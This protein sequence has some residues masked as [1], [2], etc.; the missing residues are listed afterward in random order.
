MIS[1]LDG[2]GNYGL[3]STVDNEAIFALSEKGDV[4]IDLTK[5]NKNGAK[6]EIAIT[7]DRLK[8]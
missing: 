7:P 6:Q 8:V 3:V 5:A 2:V 1:A 4:V